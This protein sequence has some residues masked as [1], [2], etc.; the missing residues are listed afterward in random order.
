[1]KKVQIRKFAFGAV[2]AGALAAVG[3]FALPSG[4]ADWAPVSYGLTTS[5]ER[6]VPATVSEAAPARVVSTTIDSDGRPVVTVKEATDKA[7]AIKLVEDA[8]KAENAIGVEMDAKVYALGVPTGSDPSRSQQWGL[9]KIR[10]NEAWQRS[11]GAGVKVAVI[12]SGVDATHP[13]LQGNVLSGFDA[14][15]DRAGSTT[16]RHG[17]GTHVAGTIAAVTG[18]DIGV[19][20]VAPDVKIIPVKVLSD[21]GSGNMSD[22]AEGIIWAA[23]NGAQ[24]LNMS[25][26][27]TSKVAAVTNAISY[28]RSKGVTVIAAVGND[29]EKGSPTSYPGAD[30]G[31]IGVAATDSGDRIG[32]YS[33]AGNYVDVAAPGTNIL[34]TYPGGQYK[35]M[36][37]TS[38]ATP[39]VAAVAALLKSYQPSLTPDQIEAAL[40]KSAVDLGQPGFDNDFGNGRIDAVAA[41]NAVAPA[42]T[43]PTTPPTKA[44]TSAPTTPPTKA[45]TTPPT[46]APITSA[47]VTTP[48]TTAPTVPGTKVKPVITANTAGG[49]VTYGTNVGTTFTITAGGQAWARKPVQV[50]VTEGGTAHSCT[51]TTTTDLGTVQ[52]NRTAKAYFRVVVTAAA[53]TESEAVTSTAVGY[54]VWATATLAKNAFGQVQATLVGAIGRATQIQQ[55]VNGEWRTV[56]AYTAPVSPMKV[57]LTGLRPGQTYRVVV[58]ENTTIMGVTSASIV[59]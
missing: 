16:D 37:G 25:L 54:R 21:S 44:P 12:D 38:M 23:D 36:M 30:A 15:T 28:A 53:T 14:I 34:S 9:D 32:H 29:R 26:G 43:A 5:P 31:V 2:A 49:E 58:P 19:A 18:N 17:H 35:S 52:V 8:Q 27:S 56:G 4:S 48:P 3:V 33:T 42:T 22:T 41:L 7:S 11:T 39:H 45:P 57:T 40:E 50:C 13:D 47:P 24:I 10:T 51:I 59:A 6:M 46:K 20:A 1:M 55:S